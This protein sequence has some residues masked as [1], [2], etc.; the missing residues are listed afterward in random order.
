MRDGLGSVSEAALACAPPLY[1]A[2]VDASPRSRPAPSVVLQAAGWMGCSIA[3][4]VLM[5]VA[6]RQ[7]AGRV[8]T[9]EILFFRSVVSLVILLAL[10]P[11]LGPEM[12]VSRQ[13]GL[14]V[15]RNVIHFGGQYTWVW[16]IGLAPLAV[17]T[18]VEFT[19]PMWVA[20]LAAL[21]LG[22]RLV[23][24]RWAAIAG[25]LAGIALI[26]RPWT[27]GMGAE[28]LVVLAAALCFAGSTL[29]VKA[30]LR[31]DRPVTV[32]FYMSVIQLPIGLVPSLFV[33]VTPTWAD[34]PWLLAMG[35]TALG[36]HY[37]MAQ[38]LSR[39][40]A[41][42]VLPMDFMRLPFIAAAGW[43]LYGEAVDAWTIAGALLIFAGNYWSVRQES[44]RA[45]R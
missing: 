17:V 5:S 40:D 7:L 11:R 24:H 25:G 9:I 20:M 44:R 41:S 39:A 6:A 13:L 16:G 18:A 1:W 33:W 26:V 15:V 42:F 22:E 37:S 3:A 19:T 34:A 14:Q 30:L 36:A 10:M 35:V 28:T 38:A 12:L 8:P 45:G 27:A 4:F 43:T 31:T 2:P 23:A 21:V 29:C 32:V